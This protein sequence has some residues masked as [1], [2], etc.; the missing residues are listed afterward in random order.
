MVPKGDVGFCKGC[1]NQINKKPARLVSANLQVI[2]VLFYTLKI[3]M[4][5]DD[6]SF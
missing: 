4:M 5:F 6:P 1:T 2:D 3:T